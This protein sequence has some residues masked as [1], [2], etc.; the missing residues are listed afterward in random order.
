MTALTVNGKLR[1]MSV[2]ELLWQESTDD[3]TTLSTRVSV[4]PVRLRSATAPR[5]RARRDARQ[6][7]RSAATRRTMS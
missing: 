5:D 4:A 6:R 2:Y 3:L 7:C 1:D